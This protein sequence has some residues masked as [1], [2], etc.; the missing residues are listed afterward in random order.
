VSERDALL[1]AIAAHPDEDT[2]RLVFADWLDEH[3]DPERA[4]F[5]RVQI[6][7][8]QNADAKGDRAPAEIAALAARERV[9]LGRNRVRWLRPLR[10]LGAGT[11][12]HGDFWRGFVNDVGI[13]A[14][15]FVERGNELWTCSPVV[16]LRLENIKPVAKQLSLCP[17]LA[18]VGDL[19][20]TGHLAPGDLR[21]LLE[22][23]HLAQLRRLSLSSMRCRDDDIRAL[24]ASTGLP[25]LRELSLEALHITGATL[26]ALL[27]R[28]PHLERLFLSLKRFNGGALAD[29][30]A[31]LNPKH[32]RVLGTDYTP[33]GTAG[34]QAIAATH[35]TGITEL[36][37]RG[38]RFTAESISALAGAT[39]LKQLA[40]LYLGFDRLFTAG[41]TALANWPGLRTLRVLHLDR[42]HIGRVG[43]RA[44][45]RSAHLGRPE[46]LFLRD[47]R[48]GDAGA[49]AIAASE[50]FSELRELELPGNGITATGAQAL[51]TSPRL[52]RLRLLD[53]QDNAIGDAGAAALAASPYLHG[54]RWLTA[55][56][57]GISRAAGRRLL[58][59]FPRLT[60][61]CADGAF[62]TDEELQAARDKLRKR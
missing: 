9:L 51:A 48:I 32:F 58:T 55:H 38:C 35:L 60:V 62:L 54:L 3:G 6:A 33:L 21:A 52:K 13:D 30:L 20:L 15:V 5:I 18:R 23:P 22:S 14:E 61:F 29:V 19:A 17:H 42:C 57:N 53:L 24:A 49:E 43:A 26:P 28:F 11:S 2:P 7:L 10:A 4:E 59:A 50:G 16:E 34:M 40:E 8:A 37:M 41:G 25:A 45:A 56:D 36:W 31:A 46:V 39:H 1:A 47:N 12:L 27:S 44:L